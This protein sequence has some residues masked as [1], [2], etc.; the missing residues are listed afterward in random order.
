M[1]GV[2]VESDRDSVLVRVGSGESGRVRYASIHAALDRT[3]ART[4]DGRVYCWGS[5]PYGGL[6]RGEVRWFTSAAAPAQ[7]AGG[8]R[9]DQRAGPQPAADAR[10]RW[11]ALCEPHHRRRPQLRV[12]GRGRGLLLGEQRSRRAG[13]GGAEFPG[14]SRAARRRGRSVV[15]GPQRGASSYLRRDR[16][17]R[18]LLLGLDGRGPAGKR[19]GSAHPGSGNGGERQPGP[20]G[21]S[22]VTPWV[23]LCAPSY[24][25]TA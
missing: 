21:G 7:I 9:F 25:R 16:R 17:G 18:C 6:G 5:D 13:P 20:G 3:C 14:V 4:D 8:W 12:D 19:E 22:H 2:Q 10:G 15:R 1:I 23:P 24:D 11:V